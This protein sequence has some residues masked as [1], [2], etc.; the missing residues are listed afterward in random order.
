MSDAVDYLSR[1]FHPLN[2][3]IWKQVFEKTKRIM[4]SPKTCKKLWIFPQIG[5]FFFCKMNPMAINIF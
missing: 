2:R 5:E 1:Y 4:I 3:N